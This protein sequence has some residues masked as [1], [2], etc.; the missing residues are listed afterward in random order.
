M[1]IKPVPRIS[2]PTL[3]L[4]TRLH[5]Q[6][7]ELERNIQLLLSK[8]LRNES[9]NHS[10][11]KT[12]YKWNTCTLT[13]SFT[14]SI[15]LVSFS[16]LSKKALVPPKKTQDCFQERKKLKIKLAITNLDFVFLALGNPLVILNIATSFPEPTLS[17][18]SERFWNNPLI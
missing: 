3:V 10:I 7:S 16:S 18:S 13:F 6:L 4:E 8:N 12:Q 1:D 2:L 9:H 11:H 17:L 14:S 15:S 5:R